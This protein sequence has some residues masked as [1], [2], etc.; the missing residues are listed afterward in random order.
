[1]SEDRKPLW[2]LLD[3]VK[4]QPL[5]VGMLKAMLEDLDPKME[6]EVGYEGTSNF[7]TY[8]GIDPPHSGDSGSPLLVIATL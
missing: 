6:V 3:Y 7:P 2:E 4:D 5:T 1:M 8:V